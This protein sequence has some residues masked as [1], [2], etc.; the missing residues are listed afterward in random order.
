MSET[1]QNGQINIHPT[2]KQFICWQKLRDTVTNFVYFGGGAGGGKSWILCEWLLTNCY[3]YP[4]TRWFLGRNELKRLM[5]TTF[6]TFLRVVSYYEI[7]RS[8]FKLNSKYNFVEFINGSRI[9]LL[10]LKYMPSD[11]EFERFGS[12]EFTGGG[13]DESGEIKSKCVDI[14]KI[15][16]G[17]WKNKEYNLIVKILFTFNPNKGW[18]FKDIYKNWKAGSLPVNACLIQALYTDNPHTAE[19][20]GK[21]LSEI[22]DR[23][24]KERM[25]FGNWEYDNDDN[26]I[27]DYENIIDLFTNT[28]EE[29]EK[30]SDRYIICD[31]ARF[32]K[33]TTTISVWFGLNMT[34]LEIY[35]K[36]STDF[37]QQRIKEISRENLVPYSHILIDENGVGGG[38][39]DQINGAKGFIGNSSPF[40]LKQPDNINLNVTKSIANYNSLKDQCYYELAE[41]IDQHKIAI[42]IKTISET[43][44]ENL[45]S[46]LDIQLKADDIEKEGKYKIRSKDKVK[47][48][49][50]R[51]P[52]IAD[53]IMM[54]IY[55][56][57]AK[58][59]KNNNKSYTMTTPKM[60]DLVI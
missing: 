23:A 9:D 15:R 17:R 19:E 33:D 48:F 45:I 54:R 30:I 32:G 47:E 7:P 60:R 22:K 18:L 38:V 10:D 36:K 44:K 8:D 31:P 28:I 6:L 29:T 2:N 39:I 27:C 37:T 11:P 42:K 25:M 50:G 41:M 55:F 34:S 24:T 52:D 13:V 5:S 53:N 4:G 51:S 16:C 49:L 14:L 35:E 1:N 43:V 21:M 58:R 3:M 56:E 20:Y 46:E 57:L 26:S 12:L 59:L 40:E